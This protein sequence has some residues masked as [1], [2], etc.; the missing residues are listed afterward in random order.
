M[1]G[2]ISWWF[3]DVG[4]CDCKCINREMNELPST[5]LSASDKEIT[6]IH[7]LNT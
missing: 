2:I 4:G 1:C 5:Y 6:I 3:E 7:A